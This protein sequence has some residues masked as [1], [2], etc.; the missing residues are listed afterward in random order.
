MVH[1]GMRVLMAEVKGTQMA[2][3]GR[4]RRPWHVAAAITAGLVL[5]LG[6]TACATTASAA[7]VTAS[8]PAPGVGPM[9]KGT[10]RGV[11][12]NEA[13]DGVSTGK[14]DTIVEHATDSTSDADKVKALFK[15][16]PL[17]G[18]ATVESS[19]EPGVIVVKYANVDHLLQGNSLNTALTYNAMAAF[20]AVGDAQQVRMSVVSDNE[21]ADA[22]ASVDMYIYDRADLEQRAGQPLDRSA[23]SD[24][25][26]DSLKDST[27]DNGEWVNGASAVARK[28]GTAAETAAIAAAK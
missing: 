3:G 20:A 27:V 14:A 13:G 2:R 28:V 9:T 6:A 23:L 7:K 17:G 18:D 5:A 21:P 15:A 4:F 1:E 24:G 10:V 12:E 8:E 16:L 11:A 26:W 19:D 25:T 22:L